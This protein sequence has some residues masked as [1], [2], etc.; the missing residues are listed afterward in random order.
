MEGFLALLDGQDTSHVLSYILHYFKIFMIIKDED[1][2]ISIMCISLA[3]LATL[4]LVE[5]LTMT[6]CSLGG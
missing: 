5:S 4:S 6:S 2:S 3:L 1:D